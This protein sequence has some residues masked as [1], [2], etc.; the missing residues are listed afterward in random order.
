LNDGTYVPYVPGYLESEG[1]EVDMWYAGVVDAALEGILDSG[2]LLPNDPLEDWVLWNLE[3]N[4]FVIAPNLADEACNVGHGIG[5]VRRDQPE[6]A[7]YTLYGLLASHMSRQTLTTFEHRSWG[8]GRIWDCAPWAMGYYTRMLSNMIC[9]D[10][11][12]EIIFCRAVPR[13]WLDP[14]KRIRVE[15]LQTRF[16]PVSFTLEAGRDAI[17][18]V[19]DLPTRYRP[20]AAGLRLRVNGR[21]D[22]VKLNGKSVAFDRMAGTVTL[23][24]GAG[25]VRVEAH[26][27]RTR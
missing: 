2:I 9:Y 19:V 7:V 8:M 16:G 23:P 13:A 26:V 10:E 25:R 27:S 20:A 15:R 5:Y 6:L 4:L 1:H 22:S 14:G 12:D 3:D 18:G 24:P 21:I 11:G 17:I